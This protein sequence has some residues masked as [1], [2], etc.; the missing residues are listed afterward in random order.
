MSDLPSSVTVDESPE[1]LAEKITK[2]FV[3]V[4]ATP[5]CPVCQHEH[6]QL[7]QSGPLRPGLLM[8]AESE[9]RSSPPYAPLVAVACDQCGFL[10]MHLRDK[11]L[12]A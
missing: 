3:G 7:V 8:M 2:F 12:G 1:V 10:R 9:Q 6:W 11:V 5:V 4:G